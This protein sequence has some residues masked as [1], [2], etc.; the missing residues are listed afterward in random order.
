M[1]HVYGNWPVILEP[2]VDVVGYVGHDAVFSCTVD[3]HY[4]LFWF[5]TGY[6]NSSHDL[7]GPPYEARTER[8]HTTLNLPNVTKLL[9]IKA[10]AETNNTVVFCQGSWYDGTLVFANATLYVQGMYNDEV[11]KHTESTFS[12]H[13]SSGASSESRGQPH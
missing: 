6:L 3:N 11:A 9:T 10:S 7:Q 8:I 13:R 1:L 2:P 12:H 5:L 4:W